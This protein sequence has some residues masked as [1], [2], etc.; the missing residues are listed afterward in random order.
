MS[1]IF[2]LCVENIKQTNVKI[3]EIFP[4]LKDIEGPNYTNT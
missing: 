2:T 4:I 3:A 1:L